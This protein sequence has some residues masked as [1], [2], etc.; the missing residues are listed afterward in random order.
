MKP[1][2]CPPMIVTS[3]SLGA[4]LL[5]GMYCLIIK[6]HSGSE[7]ELV[8]TNSRK[9]EAEITCSVIWKGKGEARIILGGSYLSLS[10]QISLRLKKM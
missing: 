1:F 7:G 5:S 8:A 4:G 3:P 10:S 9:C 2:P 6:R